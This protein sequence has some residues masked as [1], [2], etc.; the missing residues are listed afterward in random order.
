[1]SWQTVDV[2][3]KM[4]EQCLGRI[5]KRKDDL[6]GHFPN[7]KRFYLE[8]RC[9]NPIESNLICNRCLKWKEAGFNTK[10]IYGNHYGL[11][12]EPLPAENCKIFDSPWY[13][14]M[15]PKNGV[16]NDSEMAK[17]KLAQQEARKGIAV[18]TVE[19]PVA[20]AVKEEPKKRGRKKKVVEPVPPPRPPS[21]PPEPEPTPPP[22]PPVPQPKPSAGKRRQKKQDPVPTP[23]QT[24]VQVQAV[25][26]STPS[27]ELEIVKIVVRP[28]THNDVTYFRDLS[29]N[30]LYA[31]GK[32]KR[33]S[34]YVGRWD[35]ETERIDTDFPDSDVEV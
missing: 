35:A 21:P 23:V 5:I 2:Y 6:I 22:P 24:K 1:M 25:E 32:D 27:S 34:G 30:K 11:I 9:N 28:F 29:K 16:P 26:S 19:A 13:H 20:V 14:S 18:Q 17:A 33:P 12:T 8:F 4:K 7:G 15:V 3:S 31:V 10:D